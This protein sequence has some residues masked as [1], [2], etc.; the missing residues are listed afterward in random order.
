MLL[1]ERSQLNFRS[2]TRLKATSDVEPMQVGHTRLMTEERQ[3]RYKGNLCMYCAPSIQSPSNRREVEPPDLSSVPSD[4]HDLAP[5]FSKV[6]ALSLPPHR[7]YDCA[8]DLLPG[9]P[10]PSSGL[11]NIS[12]PERETMEKYIESLAAGIIRS[13]S[14][15][16]GAGFF[17]V[18]KKDGTLRPCIDYRGLNQIT[19]KNKYPLPLLA[20]A[21]EPIQWA[22]VFT[23]LDLR[24]AYHLLRMRE[25]DEWKTAFKTPLGQFEYLVMPFGLTNAPAC[26][27]ALVNDV[28]RDFL[29][30]FVFVYIDDILIYSKNLSDHKKHVRLVLQRRLE[31]KLFVKAEKCEFHQPSV[32]FLGF[33]LE[34]GQVK[35]SEDKIKAVLDW[36]TPENRKQLQRLSPAEQNYDVGDREL[37]AI[38][39]A[40]E[41]WRHWLE[42]AEHP[43]LVWTDHK[44]LSYI[45]SVKRSNPRYQPPLFPTDEKD[46]SV[47]SVQHHIRRLQ[48]IWKDTI[49]TLNQTSA[50][51]KRFADRRHR[52]AP[53]YSPGQQVW[54]STRDIPLKSIS[55]KLSPRFIGPYKIASVINPSAVRLHLPP[56]LRIHPTFHVSQIKPVL[57]SPLC[58]PSDSPP[59]ARDINGHPA[60]TVHRIVDSR[61]R[62]CGWQYLVVW[63][64]YGPDDRTWVLGSFILDP[65][66]IDDYRESL[67]ST[68]SGPPGGSR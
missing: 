40:L 36:P 11:F 34:G 57:T 3:R 8:I 29:N 19:I 63:E 41:E 65:S 43:V 23:K 13:S 30:I 35:P 62:D 7:P 58:P 24:N 14:S 22:T 1:P 32:T 27:Q 50:Q 52:P 61:C 38:K 46:I 47:P 42:G 55:R 10:L 2:Q 44:N 26:F 68:S 67:P 17:F 48:K 4:Y 60:F 25:G 9:A 56:S 66:L 59:P 45:Q 28:L 18:G 39:W 49:A 37:L 64:G 33:V 20:S 16:L 53:N 15:P 54:L 51:N 5:V 12:K 6:S 31:N 21:F